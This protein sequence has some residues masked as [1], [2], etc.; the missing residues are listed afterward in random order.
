[1]RGQAGPVAGTVVG[2]EFQEKSVFVRCKLAPV[3]L[4]V[5]VK[6]VSDLALA[7]RAPGNELRH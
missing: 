1:M 3:Y 2:D 7:G 6:L 4:I 5:D